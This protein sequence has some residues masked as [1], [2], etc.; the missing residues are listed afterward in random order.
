[1]LKITVC[2]NN[3]IFFFS[4]A[5]QFVLIMSYCTGALVPTCTKFYSSVL[6]DLVFV[7]YDWKSKST[8]D[9]KR[10]F[11]NKKINESD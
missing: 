2:T 8:I 7:L 5:C 1:M 3:K 9:V 4:V 6:H 10:H 11:E